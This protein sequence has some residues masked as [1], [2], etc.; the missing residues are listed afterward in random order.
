MPHNNNLDLAVFPMMSKRHSALLKMYSNLQAPQEEI[1]HTAEEV[2][3]SLGSAEIACG[4][5]LAY[6]I[7]AK[8]MRVVVRTL[9]FKS[10]CF[11][12][13]FRQTFKILHRTWQRRRLL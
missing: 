12:L 8:V 11:I 7:A 10:R 3:I 2:W 9:S 13:G 5:I 6:R 1:W 4:C